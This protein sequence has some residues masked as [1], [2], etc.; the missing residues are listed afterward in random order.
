MKTITITLQLKYGMGLA[1]LELEGCT[2]SE[3]ISMHETQV[4]VCGSTWQ[5]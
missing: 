5:I 3:C 1:I 4:F 2:S